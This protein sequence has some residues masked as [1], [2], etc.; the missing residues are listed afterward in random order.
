MVI[1][2]VAEKMEKSI[3]SFVMLDAFLPET[4]EALVDLQPPQGRESFLAAERNGALAMPPR[5]A[6]MFNVNEKDRAWVDAQCTPHP[7]KCFLQKLTLTRARERI[8]KKT[9][10]RATGYASEPFDRAMA[11]ARVKGWR[12]YQV[13]CGHDVLLDMPERPPYCRKRF[14]RLGLPRGA[15]RAYIRSC[16]R[17]TRRRA[18]DPRA[19]NYFLCAPPRSRCH[20]TYASTL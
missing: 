17:S 4:G 19:A 10:I 12:V 5:A 6:A 16:S 7:L 18:T 20:E 11:N 3:G 9:Y 14:N 8:G 1:S 13:P 15:E 2:G